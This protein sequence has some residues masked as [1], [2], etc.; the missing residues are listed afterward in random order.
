MLAVFHAGRNQ[1]R[2]RHDGAAVAEHQLFVPGV[3]GHAG[4][5]ERHDQLRAEPLRLSHSPPG[6]LA[7][8][9]AGRKPEIVLD[10][11]TAARLPARR[12]AIEQQGPQPFRGAVHSGRQPRRAGADNHQVVQREGRGQRAAETLGDVTRLGIAQHRAVLEEQRRE[13]AAPSPAASSRACLSGRARRRA[14]GTGSGC[15]RGSP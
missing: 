5:L 3:D 7:A 10:P 13:L 6:Q 9:D 1:H 14:S 8:A 4:D 2:P 11:R 15:R 12:M